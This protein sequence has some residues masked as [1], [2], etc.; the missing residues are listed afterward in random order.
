MPRPMPAAWAARRKRRGEFAEEQRIDVRCGEEE[1]EGNQEDCQQ[2]EKAAAA[3]RGKVQYALSGQDAK[4][5]RRGINSTGM[6]APSR[7]RTA[8]VTM[9]LHTASLGR[10]VACG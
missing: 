1:A 5:G 4:G 10:G 9:A 2:E 3:A 8:S 6:F 7:A